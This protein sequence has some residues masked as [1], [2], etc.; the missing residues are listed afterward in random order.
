M[1][2]IKDTGAGELREVIRLQEIEAGIAGIEKRCVA[3][4]LMFLEGELRRKLVGAAGNSPERA[5]EF[6]DQGMR[7]GRVPWFTTLVFGK[8]ERTRVGIGE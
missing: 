5:S 6:D 4:Q 2:A 8:E 1:R 7:H 3:G